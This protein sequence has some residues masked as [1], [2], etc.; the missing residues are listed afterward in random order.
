MM[1][2]N[3]LNQLIE[4]TVIIKHHMNKHGK[5]PLLV[6]SLNDY[7]TEIKIHFG[8]F[9]YEKLFESY[10]D[11]FEDNEMESIENYLSGEVCVYGD[12]LDQEDLLLSIKPSPLRIEV[13]D[14]SH[15]YRNILW[16]G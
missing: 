12:E 6:E 5:D 11:Y 14:P 13:S 8:E 9:L 2:Y 1:D 15:Q 16:Q 7:L 10:E 3:K 4:K